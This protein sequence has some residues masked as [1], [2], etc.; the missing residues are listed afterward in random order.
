MF[1]THR[2]FES[3]AVKVLD[4]CNNMDP[5]KAA[6]LIERK[7]PGWGDMDCLE[8]AAQ[9]E[10]RVSFH[11]IYNKVWRSLYLSFVG[12]GGG[13]GVNVNSQTC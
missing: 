8:M 3:L 13:W 9:A 1:S 5:E 2:E 11:L 6:M 4:E 7:Y 10:D 12:G